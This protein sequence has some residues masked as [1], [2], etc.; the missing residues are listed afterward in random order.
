VAVDAH[1]RRGRH[2]HVQV[3]ASLL[4]QV[5]QQLVQIQ[6]DPILP[7]VVTLDVSA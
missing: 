6:H 1:V 2:L 4:H 7:A 5:T 3:G